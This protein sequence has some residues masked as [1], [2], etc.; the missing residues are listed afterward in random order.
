MKKLLITTLL[1]LTINLN[2]KKPSHSNNHSNSNT[3]YKTVALLRSGEKI[4]IK[5][6]I[7][8]PIQP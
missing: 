7:N 8:W 4:S 6:I 1:L 2:A 3:L 5:A